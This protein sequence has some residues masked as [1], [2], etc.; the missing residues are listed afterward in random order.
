MALGTLARRKSF[1]EEM[2]RS[3]RPERS[4]QANGDRGTDASASCCSLE[5]CCERWAG[6]RCNYEQS[7]NGRINYGETNSFFPWLTTADW[8]VENFIVHLKEKKKES[9]LNIRSSPRYFLVAVKHPTFKAW[10]PEFTETHEIDYQR[11]RLLSF[12]SIEGWDRFSAARAD[13][14]CSK[15][16]TRTKKRKNRFRGR[17]VRNTFPSI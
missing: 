14:K 15:K 4:S 5:I 1:G 13:V 11:K 16:E 9:K 2:E 6:R 3:L 10:E 17:R 12:G 7:N 8:K